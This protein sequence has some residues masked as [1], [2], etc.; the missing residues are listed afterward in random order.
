VE[1]KISV[2]VKQPYILPFIAKQINFGYFLSSK[3]Y[4]QLVTGIIFIGMIDNLA[5]H[6]AILVISYK[7]RFPWG[8]EG[9]KKRKYQNKH[10]FYFSLQH[11]F[12]LSK[13]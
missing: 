11:K 7:N 8:R 9:D 13:F 3:F 5:L 2:V 1:G 10:G 6:L 12:I 4:E